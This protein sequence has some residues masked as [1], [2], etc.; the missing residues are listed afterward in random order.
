MIYEILS[1]Q[2]KLKHINKNQPFKATL[3][4]FHVIGLMFHG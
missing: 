4:M 2:A 1:K 3:F